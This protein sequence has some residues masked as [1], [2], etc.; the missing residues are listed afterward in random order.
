MR[1]TNVDRL[2]NSLENFKKKPL[3]FYTIDEALRVKEFKKI[4]LTTPDTKLIKLVK[5]KY[6]NNIFYQKRSENLSEQ[7]LDYK[8]SVINAVKKFN[9]YNIDIVV[10]L[11]TENPLCKSFYIQQAISN[12]IIHDS[13]MVIGTV[14]DIENN[15]YKYSKKGI[16]LISNERNQKLKLEKNTILKDVGAFH[17]YK[18]KSYLKNN[19][20]QITN[21]VLDE[22]HALTINNKSDLLLANKLF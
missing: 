2:C 8:E 15:Y 5:K 16:E 17:V 6:K 4:I 11:T 1:G 21:I 20:N 14:P 9:R 10:I 22:Q 12:L 7:N 3:I 19:I 13:D 18:Y